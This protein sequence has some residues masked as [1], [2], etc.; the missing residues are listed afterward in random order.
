MKSLKALEL[1]D[2]LAEAQT[3]LG[4]VFLYWDWDLPGAERE[5]SE[6]IE[7][8]QSYVIAHNLYAEYM[9]AMG[10]HEQAITEV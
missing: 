10:C 2:S 9:S 1:D 8:K 5:L 7:L 3:T 4:F 6:A